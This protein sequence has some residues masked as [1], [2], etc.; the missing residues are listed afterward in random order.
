[1]SDNFQT[2]VLDYGSGFSKVGFKGKKAP[3]ATFP[4]VFGK[5]KVLNLLMG[6]VKSI[7]VGD[8]AFVKRGILQMKYPIE[9]GFVTN[10]EGMEELLVHTFQNELNVEVEK[11]SVLLTQDP[12][13]PELGRE[14]MTQLMFEKFSTPSI[15]IG[16][17]A[18]L[19][20][21][22]SGRK[23]GC[24]FDAGYGVSNIVPVH[25]G[26]A[27][28][29]S[30][31][32]LDFSGKELTEYLMKILNERGYSLVTTAA[33]EVGSRVKEAVGYV[34]LDFDKELKL[35][36]ESDKFNRDFE[37][38]DGTIITLGNER[39]MCS[40]PLFQ[41]SF[42]LLEAPGVHE[43]IY[44]SIKRSDTS[45]QK[46][47]YENIILSGGTTMFDGIDQRIEKEVQNLAPYDIKVK[48]DAPPE[49]I[50]SGWIGGS[51]LASLSSFKDMCMTI[52]EY[53]EFG[54]SLIHSK[55]GD[56]SSTNQKN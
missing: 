39:F 28:K 1:M 56:K 10:W 17:Q 2:L 5:P 34:A 35:Y 30:A 50:H 9:R 12:F 3:T 4:S 33:R 20:L 53:K 40:E 31:S 42:L 51:M 23:T 16:N 6:V 22:A 45:L 41:P 14:N 43:K 44:Y 18:V 25:E 36:R 38:P 27:L 8:E 52:E 21:F 49:R 48:V 37:L 26:Y 19:S 54:V 46:D 24:V 32:C 11:H 13:N 55:C 47:L 15:Y 7:Y 29:D